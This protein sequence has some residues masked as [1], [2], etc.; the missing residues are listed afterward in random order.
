MSAMK[1]YSGSCHCGAVTFSV[2]CSVENVIEC[3]CSH[4]AQKG[5]L[6][7]FVPA[8]EFSLHSGADSLTEYRFNKKVIAHQFC[9]V[10]GVESFAHAQNKEGEPTVA[11][12]VRSLE[13]VDAAAIPRA[14]FD[15]KSL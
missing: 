9:S 12:N 4:C 10:C 11:I 15:G 13:G 2:T 1:M 14:M 5:L 6:L 3:N 8:S 7:T